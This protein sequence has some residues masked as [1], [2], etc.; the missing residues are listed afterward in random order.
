MKNNKWK[1]IFLVMFGDLA[2][3]LRLTAHYG[4]DPETEIH[5]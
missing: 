3:F 2:E 1:T 5:K 4:Q